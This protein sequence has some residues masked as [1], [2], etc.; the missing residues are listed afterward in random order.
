MSHGGQVLRFDFFL[1]RLE[2]PPDDNMQ[3]AR[4][5]RSQ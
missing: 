4:P 3:A 5:D 1:S 2:E